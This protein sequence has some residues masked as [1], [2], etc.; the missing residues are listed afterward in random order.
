MEEFR[1]HMTLTGRLPAERREAVV[2]MLRGRFA[3]TGVGPLAIEAISLCRQEAATSRFRV[4]G[5][6]PLQE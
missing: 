5:R 2:A 1:F 6:W 4:I 3:A